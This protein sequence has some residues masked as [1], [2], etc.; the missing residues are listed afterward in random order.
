M[1]DLSDIDFGMCRAGAVSGTGAT[2]AK[3]PGDTHND[4]GTARRRGAGTRPGVRERA[5]TTVSYETNK[6]D[7]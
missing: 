7:V 2:F 5:D 4:K 1:S 6:W 3:A